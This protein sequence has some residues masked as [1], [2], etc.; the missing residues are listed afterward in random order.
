MKYYSKTIKFTNMV[1][2]LLRVFIYNASVK[3][4]GACFDG[5]I[6]LSAKAKWGSY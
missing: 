6:I 3:K 2:E 5:L 1:K 4:Y